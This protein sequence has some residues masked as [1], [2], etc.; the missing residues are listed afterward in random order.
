MRRDR[1]RCVVSAEFS[2]SDVILVQVW[3]VGMEQEVQEVLGHVE[4]VFGLPG[5]VREDWQDVA[6]GV[7][8]LPGRF[9]ARF[10]QDEQPVRNDEQEEQGGLVLEAAVPEQLQVCLRGLPWCPHV[11]SDRPL[12]LQVQLTH[13]RPL[14]G[15]RGRHVRQ[16]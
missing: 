6:D 10:A 11:F 1:P 3:V 9:R 7:R 12:R 13:A 15:P 14:I 2:L 4:N 16:V 8:A 5:D